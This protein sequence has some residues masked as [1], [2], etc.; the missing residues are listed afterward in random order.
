[1]F[2]TKDLTAPA[3]YVITAGVTD[4]KLG[5][6]RMFNVGR[7]VQLL[8]TLDLQLLLRGF[9]SCCRAKKY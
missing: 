6:I 1:M 8:D 3:R 9:P 5:L 7:C 4:I 2:R